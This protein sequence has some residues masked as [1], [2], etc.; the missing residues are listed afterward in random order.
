MHSRGACRVDSGVTPHVPALP[1][2]QAMRPSSSTPA[3]TVH[4]TMP[5]APDTPAAE[6]WGVVPIGV[7]DAAGPIPVVDA[8]LS[9]LGSGLSIGEGDA[10][11]EGDGE[12]E[13]D[14]EGEAPAFGS[15]DEEG[16]ALG[17]GEGELPAG[18]THT[19]VGSCALVV[20]KC[21]AG[22]GYRGATR[23][24]L[25]LTTHTLTRHSQ[26]LAKGVQGGRSA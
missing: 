11:M 26:P 14:G 21:I 18:H 12:G 22:W 8:S 23:T 4:C 9:G 2:A 24:G 6:V 3:A 17:S 15:G 16:P 7:G 25:Q 1:A 19:H 5:R 13:S 10:S 20:L